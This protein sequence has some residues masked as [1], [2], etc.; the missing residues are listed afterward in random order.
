MTQRMIDHTNTPLA[1]PWPEDCYV[2]GGSHGIVL[3]HGSLSKALTTGELDT[4]GSYRTAFVEAFPAEP[5]TFLR[6]EGST[7]AE[8]EEVCWGNY[9]RVINCGEHEFQQ[10]GYKNG[11]GIC[12]NCGLFQMGIFPVEEEQ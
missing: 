4:R 7:L 10:R 5:K 8:A 2:Q 11:A 6:G 9:Q 3:V 12:Q 1:W